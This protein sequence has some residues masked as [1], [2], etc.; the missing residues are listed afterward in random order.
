MTLAGG[1]QTQMRRQYMVLIDETESFAQYKAPG[2][3]QKRYWEEV[4]PMIGSLV[5]TMQPGDRFVL[6]GIDEQGFDENDV[7]I[8]VTDLEDSFLKAKLQKDS[9]RKLILEL[10]PRE[11]KHNATH[12]LGSLFHAAHF[13]REDSAYESVIFCFSDMRQEPR[14]P[15]LDE[16]YG[17]EFPEGTRAYFFY[18]DAAGYNEWEKIIAVWE[19]LLNRSGLD[20]YTNERLHFFQKGEALA[21]LNEIISLGVGQ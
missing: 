3:I 21:R 2:I 11:D 7:L 4:L 9:I 1:C 19:P 10:K 16:A 15:T 12:I 8:P 13:I 6:I 5:E 14:M 20:L 17:L 18:V